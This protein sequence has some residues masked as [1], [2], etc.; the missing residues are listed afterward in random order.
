[1]SALFATSSSV[2]KRQGGRCDKAFWG[3]EAELAGLLVIEGLIGVGKTSLCR[4]LQAEW[5]A[6]LVLE[7]VDDNPFL[8]R[9]YEDPEHYA[10]PTQMFY[11]AA[12]YQQQEQIRQQDLFSRLI[13]ADYLFEKD[14]LFAEMTLKD[15][16]L[17]LYQRL[18]SLLPQVAPPPDLV[19]FLDAE[20]EVIQQRIC[21][22]N[23]S[24]EQKIPSNYL[25][26]LRERYLSLWEHWTACPVL[27]IQTDRI[28]YVDDLDC[29][30]HL[31]NQIQEAFLGRLPA[32]SG[33]LF[34]QGL[35]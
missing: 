19:V 4:I 23:L 15:H 11:M 6:R 12:R 33:S 2:R 29:R 16:E 32:A 18:V 17:S 30:K 24:F 13:V 26:G 10:F 20:T 27:K 31:L 22:R 1:V 8:A 25:N 5:G 34:S 3:L 14:R 7:P 9:F 21:R 35:S 28:N